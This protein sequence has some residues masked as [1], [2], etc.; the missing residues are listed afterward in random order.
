MTAGRYYFVQ[1][2]GSAT[3]FVEEAASPPA[4]A[5]NAFRIAP[6]DTVRV[7]RA[8]G[9]QVYAWAGSGDLNGRVVYDEDN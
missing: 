5:D 9:T 3:M 7:R 8:S 6:S 4:N 1:N 2:T